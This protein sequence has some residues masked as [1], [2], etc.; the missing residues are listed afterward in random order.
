M[1]E[2]QDVR[3]FYDSFIQTEFSPRLLR[4]GKDGYHAPSFRPQVSTSTRDNLLC[5]WP[6]VQGHLDHAEVFILEAK[7]NV[8]IY[9]KNFENKMLIQEAIGTAFNMADDSKLH[10]AAVR[11]V[12]AGNEPSEWTNSFSILD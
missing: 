2:P 4:F 3:K 10:E 11:I 6:I 1:K 8:F 5:T 7:D 12:T 9:V